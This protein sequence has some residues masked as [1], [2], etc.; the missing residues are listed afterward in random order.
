[1]SRV[2]GAI[3]L[4]IKFDRLIEVF[5][6]FLRVVERRGNG[7]PIE[8]GSVVVLDRV[9]KLKP[10][11]LVIELLSIGLSPAVAIARKTA[12]PDKIVLIM[13]GSSRHAAKARLVASADGRCTHAQVTL[14]QG[15]FFACLFLFAISLRAAAAMIERRQKNSDCVQS[16]APFG[17]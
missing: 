3:G 15:S 6:R 8:R 12:T 16:T 1:M 5:L 9:A 13:F 10:A 14:V 17:F 11:V 7:A 2:G 4:G